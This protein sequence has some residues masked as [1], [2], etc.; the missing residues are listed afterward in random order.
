LSL[1]VSSYLFLSQNFIESA[2]T[3]EFLE[4]FKAVLISPV[5]QEALKAHRLVELLED[6]FSR[7]WIYCRHLT[8]MLECFVKY[9]YCKQ[10]KFFGTYRVELVIS[11]FSRLVDLHNFEF[12]VSSS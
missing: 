11:L 1:L 4:K 7:N 2:F 8:L 12:V 10:T 9:G 5:T 6:V 3:D